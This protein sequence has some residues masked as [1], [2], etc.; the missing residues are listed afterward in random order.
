MALNFLPQ[1]RCVCILAT[2][3]AYNLSPVSNAMDNGFILSIFIGAF[4]DRKLNLIPHIKYNCRKAH[5]NSCA[6]YLAGIGV[7]TGQPY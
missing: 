6:L 3:M 2:K 4:F 5:Y 1:E 7:A